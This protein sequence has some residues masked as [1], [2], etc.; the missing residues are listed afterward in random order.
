MRH[1]SAR[2]AFW[3]LAASTLSRHGFAQDLLQIV[4]SS[5]IVSAARSQHLVVFAAQDVKL[6]ETKILWVTDKA[7]GLAAAPSTVSLRAGAM[8]IAAGGFCELTIQAQSGLRRSS[9]LSGEFGVVYESV[10]ADGKQPAA[11]RLLRQAFTVLGEGVS[12][13][14]EASNAGLTIVS[15]NGAGAPSKFRLEPGAAFRVCLAARITSVAIVNR[16]MQIVDL[17]DATNNRPLSNALIDFSSDSIPDRI[18]VDALTCLSLKPLDL[19]ISAMKV[20]GTLLIPYRTPATT[21]EI[22]KEAWNFEL[23]RPGYL[24]SAG[25]NGSFT[26]PAVRPWPFQS[27]VVK[28]CIPYA[29]T[30]PDEPLTTAISVNGEIYVDGAR[31]TYVEGARISATANVNHELCIDATVPGDRT[32]LKGRI[33]LTPPLV[34][35]ASEF[36]PVI[37]VKDHKFWRLAT[38]LVAYAF[39]ALFYWL[40]TGARAR[41]QHRASRGSISLR[42]ARFL[43]ANPGFRDHDSVVF[44]RQL[45]VDSEQQDR[46]TAFDTAAQLLASAD[47][48]M[49]QL[50][51]MPP[52]VPTPVEAAAA[53]AIR[54]LDPPE[55]LIAG[56][57]LS[58]RI[59]NRPPEWQ[60]SAVF[61][62]H[63]GRDEKDPKLVASGKEKITLRHFFPPAPDTETWN[64]SVTANDVTKARTIVLAP[65]NRQLGA[66]VKAL[67]L[68]PQFLS[69]LLGAIAAYLATNTVESWGTTADYVNL[70]VAA[71]GAS[72]GT[73]SFAVLV[74]AL[75]R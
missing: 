39:A 1:I 41:L 29:I 58:F 67:N 13:L 51:T 46:E 28:R 44:I 2:S 10:S 20:T 73:Q 61:T 19:P 35:Q 56:R 8:T 69:V 9:T 63:I 43:A 34:S 22:R 32:N 50:E 74:Q 31:P 72:A 11:R 64:V 7:T 4:P 18:A 49:T 65:E 40:T 24:I 52:S 70:F 6:L 75:R 3:I 68:T 12:A 37:L 45:L 21:S 54:V 60:D 47:S 15:A 38:A 33:R 5:V 55:R 71:F 57:T 42:L 17:F 48:R 23:Y 27:F 30:P 16:D 36:V 25:L 66:R 59:G 53:P 14:S 62:W 26:L